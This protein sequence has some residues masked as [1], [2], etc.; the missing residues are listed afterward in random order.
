MTQPS[1]TY[2]ITWQGIAI[3]ISYCPQWLASEFSGDI[4]GYNIAHLEIR[5]IEPERTRLPITETGYKSHFCQHADIEQY[6]GAIG[7]VTAWLE[8]EARSA[9]WQNH[10][11]KSRQ[12]DLFEL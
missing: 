11:E 4:D 8:S 1:Q 2:R 6:G 3:E 12:G 7:F 5:A 10:I 9:A